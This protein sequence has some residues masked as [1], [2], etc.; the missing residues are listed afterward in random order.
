MSAVDDVAAVVTVAVIGAGLYLWATAQ[1][2]AEAAPTPSTPNQQQ[3]EEPSDDPAPTVQ[4]DGVT[5]DDPTDSES[6][7]AADANSDDDPTNDVEPTNYAP[8]VEEPGTGPSAS[9]M[10]LS[11]PGDSQVYGDAPEDEDDDLNRVGNMDDET[12]AAFDR[13]ANADDPAEL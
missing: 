10:L 9:D 12:A 5:Y 1:S 6:A 3:Q 4:E 11:D 7:T 8:D 2:V 13:L